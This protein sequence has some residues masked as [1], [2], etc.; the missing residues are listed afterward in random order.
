METLHLQQFNST[1]KYI[2][3][4]YDLEILTLPRI[5]LNKVDIAQSKTTNIEIPQSGSVNIL[6]PSEG[7]GSIYVEENNKL[8]LVYNLN[9]RLTQETVV[10]QPGRYRVFYR[11]KNAKE[12]IYTIE[13][14]FKIE[15]GVSTPVRLY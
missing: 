3:G 4:K 5:K 8:T 13:R 1:E 9:S 12:S 14:A 6:T 7:P 15:S 11:P 10:L 2:V